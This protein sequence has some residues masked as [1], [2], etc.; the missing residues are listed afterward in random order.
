MG[1][2]DNKGQFVKG[3]NASAIAAQ[4]RRATQK[5]LDQTDALHQLIY[6]KS[7]EQLLDAI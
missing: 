5:I 7:L 3:N 4:K 1:Q 6:Q 2:R